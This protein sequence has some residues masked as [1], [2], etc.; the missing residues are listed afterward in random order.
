[1]PAAG[2]PLEMLGLLWIATVR[3][4]AVGSVLGVAFGAATVLCVS[5]RPSLAL[6]HCLFQRVS[7]SVSCV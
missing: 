7:V 4:V 2:R 3:A 5:V 6:S 1:M